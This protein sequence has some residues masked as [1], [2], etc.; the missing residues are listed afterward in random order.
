MDSLAVILI[1]I[2]LAAGLG[3]GWL[4]RGKIVAPLAVEKADLAARLAQTEAQRNAALQEL[5]V[6]QDRAGQAGEL[7]Q[8][9]EDERAAR[10]LAARELAALRSEAQARADAFEAQIA[11]LKDAKEQLSAQFSEI[12]GKLLHQAQSHFLERA[13]Q[14]LAQAHEKSEAQLKQLLHP[15]NETIQRYDQKISQIE[16]QRTEA[17]GILRGEIESMKA[18]Q[19]AVRAEAQRLV[20]SLRHAPK[21]RGRWGEQQLRNVLETCGLSEHV[22]FHTEVSVEGEDG[23]LRPDA[24]LRVPGGRALVIDAKVS[25]N[26]YQDAYGADGEEERKR[27]LSAHAAA[28]RAHVET[29]GRKAYAE[30]FDE[31][32]DYV[33]M[34][35]PGEHFLSAALEH[36]PQLWDHAFGKRVLL[37]TPTNLIAI[38]RTVAAVWRQEKMADEAKRIGALG[39]ELYE[40]LAGAAGSLKKLGN[41]LNGAVGDYNA[42]VGSFEGRVLVTGRKLR[43]LNIETGGRELEELEPVEALVREPASPEALRALPDMLP[44][45]LPDAAE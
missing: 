42:F 27:L 44:Q 14:R 12:G 38:A 40:R 21:A 19:E 31:A 11:A 24:I 9:L 17:Y 41:R 6:A 4:L 35:V 45:A 43:D 25:L 3:L 10:E 16:Q 28:M 13:D 7:A 26:A 36:D 15:V 34:F 39:K 32:P 8:R 1:F 37:A 22:D 20:D 30:Q 23:R 18:G 29:L 2:A 33:I 5:V